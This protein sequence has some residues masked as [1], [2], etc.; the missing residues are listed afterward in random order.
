METVLAYEWIHGKEYV[1]RIC[2]FL[3]DIDED[4]IPRLSPRVNI[5]EYAGKL[6]ER[7]ITLFVTS[8]SCD[9]ASCSVY[10]DTQNAFISSIA[11]KKEYWRHHIGTRL[12]NEVKAYVRKQGCLR[13]RLE[14]YRD[15]I[16]AIGFYKKNGFQCVQE[17]SQWFVM[18]FMLAEKSTESRK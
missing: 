7:A 18:E 10:C 1:D 9:I 15:N 13:I 4:M 2:Q 12:I 3:F 17:T 11:V 14:V 16:Q 8:N 6:A 5:D